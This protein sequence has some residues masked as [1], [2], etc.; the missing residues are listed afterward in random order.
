MLT[1]HFF[2]EKQ[3]KNIY[4]KSF[5]VGRWSN[6]RKSSP[7]VNGYVNSLRDLGIERAHAISMC[8]NC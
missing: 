2:K 3:L 8:E 7:K 6:G 5:H 4:E 1:R